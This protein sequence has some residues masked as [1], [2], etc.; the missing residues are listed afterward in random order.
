MVSPIRD[1]MKVSLILSVFSLRIDGLARS[2][3]DL[4]GWNRQMNTLRKYDNVRYT[5]NY[6]IK[7]DHFHLT[8]V[9]HHLRK[10][11]LTVENQ[12]YLFSLIF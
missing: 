9:K 7:D 1:K 3:R 11:S 2:K 6:R 4:I 5:A 8:R 10:E 12:R